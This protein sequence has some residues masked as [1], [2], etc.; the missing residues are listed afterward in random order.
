MWAGA[1][2]SLPHCQM[3]VFLLY[4][5]G[6]LPFTPIDVSYILGNKFDPIREK[7]TLLSVDKK[8]I[9]TRNS[10]TS[11]YCSGRRSKQRILGQNNIEGSVRE[12][13]KGV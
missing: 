13:L 11:V 3:S 12:K 1:C 10:H 8:Y 5:K 9:L 7:F 2:H 4:K 6:F